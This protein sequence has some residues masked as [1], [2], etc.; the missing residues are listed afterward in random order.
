MSLFHKVAGLRTK[1]TF[2]Y[3]TPLVAASVYG[4]NNHITNILFSQKHGIQFWG[5]SCHTVDLN[6]FKPIPVLMTLIH[7]KKSGWKIVL[8][9]SENCL[10]SVTKYLARHL[11]Q[12]YF[13]LNEMLCTTRHQFAFKQYN[14]DKPGKYDLFCSI[15][16][17]LTYIVENQLANET[18]I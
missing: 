4:V 8:Q 17:V 18:S 9:P 1:N 2:F 10:N 14:P 6:L 5:L 15:H 12:D 11:F 13:S 7:E 3:R 16:I